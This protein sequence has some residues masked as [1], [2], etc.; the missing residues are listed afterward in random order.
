MST[1]RPMTTRERVLVHI[2]IAF[3]L[4]ISLGGG[5]SLAAEGREG[6][7][8]LRDGPVGT[9]TP[10]DRKCGKDQCGWIGTFTSA[11]STVTERD[12]RLE[13]AVR[14]RRGDAMPG[15]IAGVRLAENGQ[16]A[17]TADYQWHGPVLKG[18]ALAAVGLAIATGLVL[19]L[20]RHRAAVSP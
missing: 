8:A 12:V 17:Y 5:L 11:D 19:M 20:R 4:F 13:D 6:R 9:L 2:G 3:A 14:V 18:I 10:T 16:T 15:A 1:R 7:T